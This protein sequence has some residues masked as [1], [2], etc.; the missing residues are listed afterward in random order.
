MR[1][2][3]RP[4]SST[5]IG[6]IKPISSSWLNCHPAS[7]WTAQFWPRDRD[8]HRAQLARRALDPRRALFAPRLSARRERDPQAG[9]G[10]CAA[11]R[12]G[13][14][15]NGF[16][17]MTDKT[18]DRVL[19]QKEEKVNRINWLPFLDTYRTMCRAPE[20]AFRQILE[21]VRELPSPPRQHGLVWGAVTAFGAFGR[22]ASAPPGSI[23]GRPVP[24]WKGRHRPQCRD[25]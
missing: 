7:G 5:H 1:S 22:N 6:S 24:R 12:R 16:Y 13:E 2:S 3:A 25:T 18:V 11:A 19:Q 17:K 14:S 21:D 10:L 15:R 9:D 8:H 20:P 4:A 23:R